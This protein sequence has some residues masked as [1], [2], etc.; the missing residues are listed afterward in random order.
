MIRNSAYLVHSINN[1]SGHGYF[2]N[3][4]KIG[5]LLLFFN[6]GPPKDE[7]SFLGMF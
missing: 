5:V 2:T 6:V 7:G 1:I 4:L 3:F